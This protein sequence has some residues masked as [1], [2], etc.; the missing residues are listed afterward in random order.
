MKNIIKLIG[1]IALAALIGLSI[2]SCPTEASDGGGS[3][4]MNT[5]KLS[6]LETAVNNTG[7]GWGKVEY[8][9]VST[10]ERYTL[11]IEQSLNIIGDEPNFTKGISIVFEKSE[12]VAFSGTLKVDSGFKGGNTLIELTNND[13]KNANGTFKVDTDAEIIMDVTGG[14]AIKSDGPVIE[15]LGKTIKAGGIAIESES[16][17]GITISSKS[18]SIAGEIIGKATVAAQAMLSVVEDMMLKVHELIVKANGQVA[19]VNGSELINEGNTIENSGRINI[20]GTGILKNNG[21][22][23]N[24][25]T[26]YN[27]GTIDNSNS[28]GTI[29]NTGAIYNI[30]SGKIIPVSQGNYSGNQPI[31][32]GGV[33]PGDGNAGNP[34]KVYDVATLQRVG[35]GTG[36]Y[37]AWNRTANYVQTANIN[38]TGQTWTPIGSS[39]GNTRFSGVYDGGGFNITG[40]T[41]NAPGTSSQGLFGCIDTGAIVKN[42]GLVACD[43]NGNQYVGGVVGYNFGTVQDCSVAGKDSGENGSYGDYIGGVVGRNQAVVQ[44]CNSSGE[45]NGK[46]STGGVVGRNEVAAC[47]VK[48]CYSS[49]TVTT[50]GSYA[51]G[52]VG[53]NYYGTVQDCYSTGDVTGNS[54]RVGGVVGCSYTNGKVL[55]CYATG[56]IRG[57][58]SGANGNSVAGVVGNNYG[59]VEYC[60]ATGDV[61]GN[62][63]LGGVVGQNNGSNG[64]GIV[65]YCYATGN[66]IGT[67]GSNGSIAGVNTEGGIVQNCY[68]TGN[69]SGSESIGGVVG[70]NAGNTKATTQN[71]YVT[72]NV[73]AT[74][75]R[76]GGVVGNLSAPVKN[77]VALGKSVI[78]DYGNPSTTSVDIG[79]TVG[80]IYDTSSSWVNN[81]AR[82][83]MTIGHNGLK[84][85][86]RSDDGSPVTTLEALTQSWWTT[87]GRW[88]EVTGTAWDFSASGAWNPV[89]GDILPTLKGMPTAYTQEP[90]IQ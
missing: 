65:Q 41:I 23:K 13:L 26:I 49:A 51:G 76:I 18:V 40:L 16:V 20:S 15:I 37:A 90:K 6:E 38:M 42:V 25:G 63:E 17:D 3:G 24:P 54:S 33:D 52:V 60:W 8:G 36:E 88:D 87:A 32:Q 55:R 72:G 69:V 83:D 70:N 77:C 71:C 82:N 62:G 74:G 50:S 28:N 22:L 56:E 80:F 73:H 45:I 66:V 7:L 30:G 44:G 21:T 27:Y 89:S 86:T 78:T 53:Y 10:K 57:T 58:G 59:T 43:I 11:F 5:I 12:N 35:K 48:D 46:S 39:S 1:I 34:F 85:G 14:T 79:K 19:V 29:N 67:G 81:Y 64:F 9:V 47:M 2:I 4:K 84:I 75:N 68:A 31:I 61:Y